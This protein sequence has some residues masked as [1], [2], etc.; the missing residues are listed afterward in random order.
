M[1]DE[2]SVRLEG[3]DA[4]KRALADAAGTIRKKAVRGALRE[5]GKV[6][7]GEARARAPVL[8]AAT[9][10]RKPGTVKRRITVRASKAA[11]QQGDEGVFINVKPAPGAKYRTTTKRV[12]GVAVKQRTLVRASKRGADSPD[13]PYYWRF[14][15]FGTRKMQARAF[16]KPAAD[17]KGPEAIGKFMDSVVPQIEKLNAKVG[18]K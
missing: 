16:L 4:L 6:I 14:L 1:A 11:R 17:A 15:E 5:A 2:I 10:R 7:Q 8:A 13:D 12:L 9:P 3:V 18:R